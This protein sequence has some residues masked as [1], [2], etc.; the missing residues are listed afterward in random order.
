MHHYMELHWKKIKRQLLPPLRSQYP[1]EKSGTLFT[2]KKSSSKRF[3]Q[4]SFE[5]FRPQGRNA[6]E[7][8]FNSW[9]E[10][11]GTLIKYMIKKI[12]MFLSLLSSILSLLFKLPK[13]IKD[14]IVTKLI[15]SRGKLAKPIISGIVMG[16]SFAVFTFGEIFS[17]ST[18]VV[19]QP[20]SADYMVNTNDII[21][22]REMALTTIPE[23]RKRSE[24]FIY[25]VVP[26]DTLFS[27]GE[28]FK[29]SI[30]A[31]NYVNG[32]T[33]G[34][35]LSVGQEITVPPAAGLIH[36]V[37][38]G[39]TLTSIAEKYD[40]PVQAIADFN[41]LLDTST[42]ALGTE[43]VIPGGKVPKYVPPVYVYEP[44]GPSS[45]GQG[46]A[47][48]NKSMCVWPTT[49]RYITQYFSW[50]HNGLDIASP[51]GSSMPPLL[52]CMDGVVVR[53]GWDPW[54]LGLHVRIDHGNG[55][56]TVYGHMSRLDVSYGDNVDRG[57]IIGLMGST[58][59]STG[60]HVHYMV[61]YN[62]AAQDPLGFTQ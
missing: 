52:A 44:T 43:L 14:F 54:G 17:G 15:W 55:Y 16:A 53:A 22:K 18:L 6:F 34:A 36:K 12:I 5:G 2:L 20:V 23:A 46:Q 28:R 27:I 35:I 9:K 3:F 60:P 21:P 8:F 58:G 49:V 51:I 4:H 40:V 38:S 10:F 31:L 57:E 30:D 19:D 11:I 45:V 62:G 7:Q 13:L 56:E 33:D 37:E 61:K 29:I 48:P 50:Y 59:R 24:S 32:L 42:L 1:R 47:S 26:G 41:Y 39:D 25:K